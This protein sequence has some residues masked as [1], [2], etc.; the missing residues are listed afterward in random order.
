M[1]RRSDGK[2]FPSRR[3][4]ALLHTFIAS[5]ALCRWKVDRLESAASREYAHRR[6]RTVEGAVARKEAEGSGAGLTRRA[7]GSPLQTVLRGEYKWPDP[8][9]HRFQPTCWS[10]PCRY[11]S[12]GSTWVNG[13]PHSGVRLRQEIWRSNAA[14]QVE[15]AMCPSCSRPGGW[16]STLFVHLNQAG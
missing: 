14:F 1:R 16:P 11:G 4:T 2:N 7:L 5:R 12:S 8:N 6:Q 9:E 13:P 15:R 3:R 10:S